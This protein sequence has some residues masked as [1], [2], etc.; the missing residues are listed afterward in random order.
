MY[1]KQISFIVRY[2]FPYCYI[3]VIILYH[4]IQRQMN[5]F[6]TLSRVDSKKF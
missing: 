4:L 1:I 3:I 2:I 6:M 5:I